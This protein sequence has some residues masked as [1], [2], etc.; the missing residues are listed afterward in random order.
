MSQKGEGG[1]GNGRACSG[2]TAHRAAAAP[3]PPAARLQADAESDQRLARHLTS[4][5]WEEPPG[6]TH[7]L[8]SIDELREY[9]AFARARCHPRLGDAACVLLAR[10]YLEMRN[11]GVDAGGDASKCARDTLGPCSVQAHGWSPTC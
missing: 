9:I 7:A 5:F 2:T 4:L 11:L 3:P 1:A 6:H 10:G 8:I